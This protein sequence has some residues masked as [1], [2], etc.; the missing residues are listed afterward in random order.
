MAKSLSVLVT[1]A[2]GNQGGVV[3]RKL[4]ENGHRVRILT[5][6]PDSPRANILRAR[7]AEV[8]RGDFDTPSSLERAMQGM[9]CVFAMGTPFEVGVQGEIQEG[10]NLAEAARKMGI[11]HYVYS[12][13]ASAN[14]E[15]GIPF[16]DSKAE[17]E[18]YIRDLHLPYTIVGP[19]YFME[20]L[21]DP[22]IVSGLE[23]GRLSLPLPPKSVLQ[24][25]ALEDLGAFVTLVMENPDE[26]IHRRFDIASDELT[27]ADMARILARIS[28]TSIA[29]SEV[30][31]EDFRLQY[32]ESPEVAT[33]YDWLN[34]VGTNAAIEPLRYQFPE[35]RWHRFEQWAREQNW[36]FLR[37][38]EA[39]A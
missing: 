34:H 33:L 14:R 18:Q 30:A 1:G 22:L 32:P 31:L 25:L 20:N 11:S 29:Y 24:Q 4:L 26:L 16:F 10:K 35:V 38:L 21:F 28:G 19:A 5:R 3:A 7:G 2:T 36:G 23:S 12:S 8:V 6:N 39:A 27:C 9:Q 13:V 37:G 17:I 15:T